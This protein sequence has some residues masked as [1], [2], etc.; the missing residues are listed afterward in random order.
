MFSVLS[1]RKKKP[2]LRG[3]EG[4]FATQTSLVRSAG[5]PSFE[6]GLSWRRQPSRP[7]ALATD[8]RTVHRHTLPQCPES[9]FIPALYTYFSTITGD[10]CLLIISVLQ[11]LSTLIYTQQAKHRFLFTAQYSQ[12]MWITPRQARL[13]QMADMVCQRCEKDIYQHIYTHLINIF[14]HT[15]R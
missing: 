3:K 4:F 2:C 10:N 6:S 1:V 13:W 11:Y 8:R 5:K 9:T 14:I 12:D 15:C 7:L